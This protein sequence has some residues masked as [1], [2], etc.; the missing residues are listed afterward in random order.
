M[1]GIAGHLDYKGRHP[2]SRLRTFAA[3][4]ADTLRHRGPDGDG[5]WVDPRGNIALGHRRLAILDLSPEGRQPMSCSCGRYVVVLNGEIYNYRELRKKLDE[6][7]G[8]PSVHWRGSSDTEVLLESICRYGLKE[9]LNNFIGMFAFALWDQQQ[10]SLYLA[11]DRMGEKPLYYLWTPGFVLF[12]SELKA[13]KAHPDFSA[14]IDR[15]A[16]DLY[17]RYAYVPA[18][19]SIF[20]GV[21]KLPA[22]SFLEIEISVPSEPKMFCYWSAQGMVEQAKRE[23]IS[24]H[25]ADLKDRVKALLK[26]AIGLQMRS[27]VPLGAFLSGGIDS[28]VVSAFMQAASDRPI[29]TFTIGFK[30]TS[31][32][33]SGHAREVAHCLKTDHTEIFVNPQDAL[34]VIPQLPHIYDEPFA[35]SSQ[36]PTYLLAKL[37]RRYVTVSLSGDGGDELFGGYNRYKLGL[38]GRSLSAVPKFLRRALARG[39]TAC[40][41]HFWDK[42]SQNLMP[43]LPKKLHWTDVGDKIHKLAPIISLEKPEDMYQSLLSHWPKFSPVVKGAPSLSNGTAD[44]DQKPTRTEFIQK[45]MY[46]DLVNYLPDDI[47][48]KVDRAGMAVGL[49]SRVPFLDHRLVELAWRLP[50]EVKIR[51]GQRKWILRQILYEYVPKSIVDRP[52]M[53][54]GVPLASWLR[55]PL[56]GW[57]DSLLDEHRLV[58]EGFFEPEPIRRKWQE[59]CSGARNWQHQLWPVLMFQGWL[60][61][62]G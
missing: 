41:P 51:N 27:D 57:A 35:D 10:R 30:E 49:E 48:V 25:E 15:Y 9:A 43:L 4:M 52:K 6:D 18:P 34:D 60:E 54:F 31:H 46:L 11:R 20:R 17:L 53:G 29:K 44:W 61:V 50:L 39:L 21:R 58:R 23:P 22:G 1:C 56:R 55:G 24:G 47:L 62:Y 38:Y 14:E 32:D 7:G 40:P 5:T 19:H 26:D 33:E 13:L 36:V 42:L 8:S 59:H 12:G 28:S 37:T 2:P 45:M 16:L 3:S